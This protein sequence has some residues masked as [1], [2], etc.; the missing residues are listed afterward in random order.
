MYVYYG[1]QSE[2][3]MR[4]RAGELRSQYLRELF[5]SLVKRIAASFRSH[6]QRKRDYDHKVGGA[7]A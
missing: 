1:T 2:I 6:D 5:G 4:R 3:E 7:A